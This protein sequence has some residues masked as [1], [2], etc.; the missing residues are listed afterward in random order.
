MKNTQSNTDTK[1][2]SHCHDSLD[3]PKPKPKTATFTIDTIQGV[4]CRGPN[5]HDR[6]NDANN[7]H[8]SPSRNT[9]N[10]SSNFNDSGN[11]SI[12]AIEIMWKS[13]VLNLQDAETIPNSII[14]EQSVHKSTAQEFWGMEQ[15]S[16]KSTAQEFWGIG[17]I[18]TTLTRLGGNITR[19]HNDKAASGEYRIPK[20]PNKP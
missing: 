5:L 17:N 1:N 15:S 14:W 10:Q 2:N 18:T 13:G 9:T 3:Y 12:P 20:P 6:G 11:N 19:E 7:E 8:P 4:N 16:H